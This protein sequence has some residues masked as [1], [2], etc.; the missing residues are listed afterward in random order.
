MLSVMRNKNLIQRKR[1]WECFFSALA[2]N[3]EM[4]SALFSATAERKVGRKILLLCGIR[5]CS[6]SRYNKIKL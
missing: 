2:H 6:L 5:L 4:F 3:E 1:S